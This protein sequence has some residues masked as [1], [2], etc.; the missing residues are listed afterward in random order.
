M[1]WYDSQTPRDFLRFTGSVLPIGFLYGSVSA[2]IAVGLK[3]AE[4]RDDITFAGWITDDNAYRIFTGTLIFLLVWRTSECYYRFW[5]CTKACCTFRAEMLEVS[6]SLVNFAWFSD[7]PRE[8]VQLFCRG[9]VTL[10]SMLHAS[11]LGMLTNRDLDEFQILGWD[12]VSTATRASL[13]KY[14]F[15]DRIDIIYMWLSGTIVRNLASG[16]LQIPPPILSRCFQELELAMVKYNHVLEVMCIPFPF[17]YAQNARV[18]LLILCLLTPFFMC[19]WTG[20]FVVTAAGTL[21]SV[22]CITSLEFVAIQLENPFGD[23]PN[24]LPVDVF[25]EILNECLNSLGKE[26]AMDV[27]K[28]INAKMMCEIAMD[29]P[30]ADSMEPQSISSSGTAI[31]DLNHIPEKS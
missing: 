27:P 24:D 8:E 19:I 29:P 26:E 31:P 15:R 7:K 13:M 6:E 4:L 21:L 3:F 28:W 30:T 11:A 9:V 14:D 10:V 17:P 5:Q 16:L 1:I 25:Q 22:M 23:D 2:L 20:H 12:N 18:L